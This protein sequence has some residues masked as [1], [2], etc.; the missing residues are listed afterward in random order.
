[1]LVAD[2]KSFNEAPALRGN[3]NTYARLLIPNM[4]AQLDKALYLDSDLVVERDITA[5]WNTQLGDKMFAAVPENQKLHFISEA[6]NRL[7]IAQESSYFN[8]GVMLLNLKKM[9]DERLLEK[10]CEYMRNNA[11]KIVFHDQDILN[12]ICN[13]DFICLP[14]HWN[15]MPDPQNFNDKE[16]RKSLL[17]EPAVIHYAGYLI[18]PWLFCSK[19]FW[20][21][22]YYHYLKST[23]FKDFKPEKDLRGMILYLLPHKS[24][25]FFYRVVKYSGMRMLYD[26]LMKLFK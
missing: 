15:F 20:K 19:A 4:A 18:A 3:K 5:L 21:E 12:A 25:P 17:E 23:P 6:K 14:R 10:A 26:K 11:D 22:R 24:I 13:G 8:A 16:Y 9:R 7:G 1:M 2:L